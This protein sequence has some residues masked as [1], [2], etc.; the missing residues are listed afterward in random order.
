MHFQHSKRFPHRRNHRKTTSI[1][2][3]QSPDTISLSTDPDSMKFLEYPQVQ[4]AL[5]PPPDL[6]LSPVRI[7]FQFLHP[8]CLYISYSIPPC[9]SYIRLYQIILI[10]PIQNFNRS[11]YINTFKA[12]SSLIVQIKKLLRSI[13]LFLIYGFLHHDTY[14]S[15][16]ITSSS[17]LRL[18]PRYT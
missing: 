14:S 4:T 1:Q 13:S 17:K 11:A 2:L 15:F 12:L 9:V 18:F 16:F 6:E 8:S 7:F 10:I 5:Y 3:L